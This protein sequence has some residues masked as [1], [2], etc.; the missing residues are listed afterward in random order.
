LLFAPAGAT[1]DTAPLTAG[2]LSVLAVLATLRS[3]AWENSAPHDPST[4]AR[5]AL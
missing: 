5:P 4:H 2:G 3:L 1:I